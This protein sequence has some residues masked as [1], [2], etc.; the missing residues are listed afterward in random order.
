MYDN[1][2]LGNVANIHTTTAQNGNNQQ[3]SQNQQNSVK[4][5]SPKTGVYNNS[6][7]STQHN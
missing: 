5:N 7:Q 2:E 4:Y 1:I 6:G 3:Q